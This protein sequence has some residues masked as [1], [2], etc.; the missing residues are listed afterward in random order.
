MNALKIAAVSLDCDDPD[1]LGSFYQRLLGG[2]IL[3]ANEGSVG[4]RAGSLVLVAQHVAPYTPPVWPNASVVHLDLGAIPDLESATARAV[5]LGATLV[6][7]Q[8]DARWNVLLDV[9][10]HP[11]CITPFVPD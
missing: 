3:W 11:F 8:P 4:V 6:Q 7:P 2:E 5:E 1:L 10:G 9:A